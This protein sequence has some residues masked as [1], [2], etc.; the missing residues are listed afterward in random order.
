MDKEKKR[1]FNPSK[2]FT[3]SFIRNT[4][5]VLLI[6]GSVAKCVIES[7]ENNTITK[8]TVIKCV[9]KSF[10]TYYNELKNFKIDINNIQPSL[11]SHFM[12]MVYNDMRRLGL[13]TIGSGTNWTKQEAQL[14]AIGNTL[15]NCL[16]NIDDPKTL[17]SL[18]L[19]LCG[20]Q[21]HHKDLRQDEA[22]ICFK[23]ASGKKLTSDEK[24]LYEEA[25]SHIEQILKMQN[26]IDIQNILNNV[27]YDISIDAIHDF[28]DLAVIASLFSGKNILLVGKPGSGKTSYLRKL[29]ESLNIKFTIKT[30]NPEWTTY[31]VV[32]GYTLNRGWQDGFL[33]RVIK[34]GGLHWLIIDEFNRA[35]IDLCLGEYFTLLDVEHRSE[36][37]QLGE[38]A[39]KVPYSFRVLGTLNSFDRA[40]LYKIGY[41]LR[42][43]FAIINFDIFKNLDYRADEIESFK[44]YVKNLDQVCKDENKVDIRIDKVLNVLKLRN[45]ARKDYVVV[46]PHLY[47]YIETS[48]EKLFQITEIDG[49]NLVIDLVKAVKCMAGDINRELAKYECD[50]CP[51]E[52]TPG[53][54]ADA[55][56]YLAT[57]R[58][59]CHHLGQPVKEWC[60]ETYEGLLRHLDFAMASYVI[61]QLDVLAGYVQIEGANSEIAKIL[62]KLAEEFGKRG[63]RV[64]HN[65]LQKLSRGHNVP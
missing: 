46:V 44:N 25:R 65:F 51:V 11:L 49:E 19:Y 61:P 17:A 55:L 21:S 53:V 54:L 41:A 9:K 58:A 62:S 47:N 12:A 36:S 50:I 29:L 23:L 60:L 22:G 16:P 10:N 59:L 43:R 48:G 2:L 63:L 30:G 45:E 64:T 3:P 31:D 56:R 5:L 13:L 39:I 27:I 4:D 52:I 40:N 37:I 14:T 28:L 34:S 1:R 20:N 24:K 8:K 35:N 15:K 6:Y 57:V 7:A 38:E 42:R 26:C 18:L 32:G 33:T